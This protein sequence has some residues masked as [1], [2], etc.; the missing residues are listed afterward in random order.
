MNKPLLFGW[1]LRR[2]LYFVLGT[3][4]AI[5][6]A[7]DQQWLLMGAGLYFVAM[8]IFRLGCA[9]NQCSVQTTKKDNYAG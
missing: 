2:I 1:T 6:S 9:G 7:L 8:A 3:W 5:Q 4:A